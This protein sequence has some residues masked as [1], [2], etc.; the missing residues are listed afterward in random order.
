M[1]QRFKILFFLVLLHIFIFSFFRIFNYIK[2]FDIFSS[3]GTNQMIIAFIDGIRFDLSIFFTF[4]GILFL[5]VLAPVNSKLFH[6]INASIIL[7]LL[8]FYIIILSADI[9]FFGNVKRHLADEILLMKN[10]LGFI[11]SFIKGNIK[12]NILIFMIFVLNIFILKKSFFWINSNLK[13]ISLTK[14]IK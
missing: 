7:I 5:L 1:K 9:E 3:L 6:K 4:S 13:R 11:T 8:N 10:D 14:K 2:Y 12:L